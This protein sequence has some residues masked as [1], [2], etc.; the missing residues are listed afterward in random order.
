MKST[1]TITCINCP[2]GCTVTVSPGLDGLSVSGNECKHGETY[3]LQEYRAPQRVLT[4]TVR[5]EGAFLPRLPVKS[6]APLAKEL[7][8]LAARELDRISIRAPV[9]CGT[10]IASNLAGSGINLIAT[11]DLD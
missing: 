5:I 10:V 9:S 4:G 2:L 7:L 11:R 1:K 8:P 6:E 3:A